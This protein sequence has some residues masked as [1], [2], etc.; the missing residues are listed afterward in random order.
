MPTSEAVTR[1][2]RVRVE[3]TFIPERSDPQAGDWFFSYQIEI[4]NESLET[5][6]LTDRHWVITDANGHVEEV[7]GSGVVGLQPVLGPGESHSY[8]SYCPLRTRF[9]TM[10]GSY[11]MSLE[12]GETFDAEVAPFTLAEPFAIN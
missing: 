2:V 3:S 4:T 9:G 1:G 5:V 11:R 8:T 7:R 10:H 6:Q 12:S